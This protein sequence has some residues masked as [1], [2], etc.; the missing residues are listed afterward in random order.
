MAL[1]E[2]FQKTIF[3]KDSSELEEKIKTLK[4][5]RDK[6]IEKDEIDREIKISELGL[7]G[8]KKIEYELKCA[9]IG[10][11]VL[12][13]VNVVADDLTAQIDWVVVT[14]AHC[15]LI[16]CKN[17]VGNVRVNAQG[18]FIRYYQYKNRKISEAIYS[19]YRQAV[20]HK[21]IWKKDWSVGKNKL[22]QYIGNS[23]F[24]DWYKPLVVFANTSGIL[25]VKYAPTEIKNSIVKVDNLIEY[26]KNDIK[27]KK[28]IDL[29]SRKNM[30][31]YATDILLYVNQKVNK[32]YTAKYTMISE[33]TNDI[34]QVDN[35]KRA[36]NISNNVEV[37]LND[38][39]KS[40]QI[41]SQLRQ[42]LLSYRKEKSAKMK[43]PAYYV[44]LN[45]E[46]EELIKAK[47][48]TLEDLRK[49]KILNAVKIKCHGAEIVE[50]IK[51]VLQEQNTQK[52]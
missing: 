11:Y 38:D 8:E 1:F 39:T 12:H 47:P 17:L 45:D 21:E 7:V 40:N 43:I 41:E 16:E 10:M 13:D 48:L 25:D 30:E 20:R 49:T 51:N 23:T 37:H 34:E 26:L 19:P 3:V 6:V 5:I 33:N 4:E 22:L 29:E 32:D 52:L 18:E 15:Y 36:D 50:M 9:N 35:N 31:S 46:L 44:F 42:A 24:E 2:K 14:P 28:F 27:N